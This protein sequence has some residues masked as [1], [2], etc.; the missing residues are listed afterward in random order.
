MARIPVVDD[1]AQIRSMFRAWLERA[2]YEVEEAG[3]GE[4]AMEQYRDHPA[5]LVMTDLAM[6]KKDGVE[7]ILDL[8]RDFP[9]VKIIA[10]SGSPRAS[11]PETYLEL[12]GMFGALRTFSKP[13]D[14][15]E[16]LSAVRELVGP[17]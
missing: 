1:N 6:P 4:A 9:D 3:D 14:L 15:D 13:V 17:V 2:G 11:D 7:T 5:D 10:V 12:A 8:W 16:L